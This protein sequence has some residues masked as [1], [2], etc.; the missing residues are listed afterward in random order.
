MVS[1]CVC[2][3]DVTVSNIL[4]HLTLPAVV[5]KRASLNE[6]AAAV[7][8]T[9]EYPSSTPECH[10]ATQQQLEQS[11]HTSKQVPPSTRT[12]YGGCVGLA[13]VLWLSPTDSTTFYSLTFCPAHCHAFSRVL[14]PNIP[15]S[16]VIGLHICIHHIFSCF[17]SNLSG[18]LL[19]E[20][21]H[22]YL[23]LGHWS[24]VKHVIAS[25]IQFNQPKEFLQ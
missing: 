24:Q 9:S 7:N 13:C 14:R 12:A 18:V 5:R 15:C 4:H 2:I 11:L 23:I 22:V 17:H 10:Q 16:Y 6:S 8:F 21:S 20:A 3:Q 1:L 25:Y 19:S